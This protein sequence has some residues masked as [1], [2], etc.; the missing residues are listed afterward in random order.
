[1]TKTYLALEKIATEH[2]FCTCNGGRI[3]AADIAIVLTDGRSQ[4]THRTL[5]AARQLKAQ[6]VWIIAIG[7][8]D[9]V[10]EELYGMASS[11]SDVF[12]S[13]DFDTLTSILDKVKERTCEACKRSRH[14][15]CPDGISFA[16]GPKKEGC[17]TDPC[18]AQADIIL[19]L[20]SSASIQH[21][22]YAKELS[23]A[24]RI[25]D[26]FKI[27]PNNVRFAAAAFGSY[28]QKLFD[29][30]SYSTVSALKQAIQGAPFLNSGTKTNKALEMVLN[31]NMFSERKGGRS[32]AK[33][34]VIV[35]TDGRSTYAQ[36]TQRAADRLKATN[37]SIISVGIGSQVD[38]T[39]LRGLASEANNV[40]T[41]E[42][43][44]HLDDIQEEAI[45]GAPFLNSGTKTNKALEMVLN[46]N[47][48]SERKGGRSFAKDMVIV[49]T[50]GRSTYAQATQR[51]ADRLK[52]TNVSIISVGIG[53]QV[54]ITELRGL[55]SEA[56]NVFTTENFDHLDDIQE[57]VNLRTCQG[58]KCC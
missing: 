40:F 11:K 24:S 13:P 56:N 46:E 48:F 22:D 36:A 53:S 26:G 19:L 28:P 47:M 31:E 25:T 10:D 20:D 27:G 49:I 34:M 4:N 54:D 17:G 55:A 57:E 58:E 32:F 1:M 37:V 30:N 51:A 42:N 9:A 14:G 38:I 6:G 3:T 7:I 41:T 50:D 52:A 33:D 18:P 2:L 16:E 45:Q 35:I 21:H 5:Q 12:K 23:F 29:L 15:C 44:D 39:E 43:F 8:A